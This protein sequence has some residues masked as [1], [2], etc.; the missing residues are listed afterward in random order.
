[1]SY[2]DHTSSLNGD[3]PRAE[4]RQMYARFYVCVR[5]DASQCLCDPG[6]RHLL[7]WTNWADAVKA[8]GCVGMIVVNWESFLGRYLDRLPER[9]PCARVFVRTP[10]GLT[11]YHASFDATP[12]ETRT[13]NSFTEAERRRRP[14]FVRRQLT[15]ANVWPEDEI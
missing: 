10:R 12:E 2:H 5:V 15:R 9:P 11:R 1:M 4:K 14:G 7:A 6:D 3:H 13:L 8:A